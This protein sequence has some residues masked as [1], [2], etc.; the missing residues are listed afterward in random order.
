MNEQLENTVDLSFS[1]VLVDKRHKVQD[2]KVKVKDVEQ[3]RPGS[4]PDGTMNSVQVVF[5]HL[6]A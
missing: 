3:E 4:T 5:D 1:K 6:Y 2:D